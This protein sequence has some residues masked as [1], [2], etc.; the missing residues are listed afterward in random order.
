MRRA[1][2]GFTVDLFMTGL[3]KQNPRAA[4]EASEEGACGKGS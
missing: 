1:A 4:K 2:S 3:D